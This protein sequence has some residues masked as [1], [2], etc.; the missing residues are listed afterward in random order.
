MCGTNTSA[1]ETGSVLET[2]DWI[3][4][5]PTSAAV[6]GSMLVCCTS[7]ARA[8]QSAGVVGF[9]VAGTNGAASMLGVNGTSLTDKAAAGSDV[10][11]PCTAD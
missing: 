10:C 11:L 3:R 1:V 8:A 4:P 7:L 5:I 2:A 9:A 6:L